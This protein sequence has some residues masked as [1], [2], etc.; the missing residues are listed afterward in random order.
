MVPQ[1][2]GVAFIIMQQVQPHSIIFIIVSQQAWIIS[3]H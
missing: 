3:Q 1:Q 2:T